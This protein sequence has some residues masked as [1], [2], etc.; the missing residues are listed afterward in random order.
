MLILG[1]GL[2]TRNYLNNTMKEE[3]VN[4]LSIPAAILVASIVLGG[5]YYSTEANKQASIERQEQAQWDESI[6]Q[7]KR[8]FE[9]DQK[10]SCLAIYK[11]E[12]VKWNNASGWRY[13]AF[14]N[15]CYIQYDSA[16]KKTSKQCDAIYTGDDGK[17]IPMFATEWL[18]CIDGKFEKSF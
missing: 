4:K 3:G 11:Q 2:K 16:Q 17:V 8:E 6:A 14:E 18:L 1:G 7:K 15:K 12:S 9:A 5:F 13:N 10:E